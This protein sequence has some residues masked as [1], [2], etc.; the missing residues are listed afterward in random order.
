ME[1]VF[2]Q[3][4]FFFFNDT[5]TTEIYTLSL[6]DALPIWF[7][8]NTPPTKPPATTPRMKTRF[9]NPSRRQS[10]LKYATFPG[11]HAAQIWRKLLET[12]NGL[13]PIASRLTATRP[14]SGPVTYHGQGRCNSSVI[15]SAPARAARPAR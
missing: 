14:R 6:H 3:C 13:L 4:S 5:A 11:K 12:P 10:Y 1:T 7:A 2:R 9:H 8:S 15:A